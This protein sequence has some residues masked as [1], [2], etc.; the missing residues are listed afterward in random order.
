[1]NL[2]NA[3]LHAVCFSLGIAFAAAEE[4]ADENT[5][6]E[7]TYLFGEVTATEGTSTYARYF[8]A[9]AENDASDMS[10]FDY[11]NGSAGIES[12]RNEYSD[13]YKKEDVIPRIHAASYSGDTR[14]PQL[15]AESESATTGT[16]SQAASRGPAKDG[17]DALR[18]YD[19]S[20]SFDDSVSEAIGFTESNDR[21]KPVFFFESTAEQPDNPLMSDNAYTFLTFEKNTFTIE[22]NRVQLLSGNSYT[23]NDEKETIFDIISTLISIPFAMVSVAVCLGLILVAFTSTGKKTNT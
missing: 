11:D 16:A 22:Q 9:S 7:T 15:S 18:V 21:N 5:R 23:D 4:P 1:M 20:V 8:F 13:G 12:D 17:E 6:R 3:L 19:F 2:R 10:R 14:S